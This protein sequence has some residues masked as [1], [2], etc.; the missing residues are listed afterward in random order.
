MPA[1]RVLPLERNVLDEVARYGTFI[2]I[3]VAT[4]M[5]NRPTID[6]R[7]RLFCRFVLKVTFCCDSVVDREAI[8]LRG[9]EDRYLGVERL[10]NV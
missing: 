5:R 8:G 4:A 7:V 9:S 1:A 10:S 3:Q 2:N 6:A